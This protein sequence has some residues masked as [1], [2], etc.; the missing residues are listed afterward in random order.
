MKKVT[1]YSAESWYKVEYE[2]EE[3]WF[4]FK[5][6][7]IEEMYDKI[8][9]S[10]VEIEPSILGRMKWDECCDFQI[11]THICGMYHI[12]QLQIL[13]KEMYEFQKLTFENG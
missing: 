7:Y 1:T 4:T 3:A 11:D 13:F 5:A 8:E 6:Y 10:R 9:E 2:V 12:D